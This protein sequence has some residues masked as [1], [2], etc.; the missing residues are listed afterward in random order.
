MSPT[1]T[2]TRTVTATRTELCL[3]RTPTNWLIKPF[4]TPGY[5]LVWHPPASC[6]R[7][8]LHRIQP[9]HRSRWYSD[10]FDRMHLFLDWR[11]GR[12][13]ISYT[14]IYIYKHIYKYIYIYIYIHIY[15]YIYIYI[16]VYIYIYI[17]IVIHR[18]ICFVLSDLIS[19]TRHT[20][21]S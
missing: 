19:V 21:F 10:I 17:Y 7:T 12:G 8:H 2:G 20:R 11:L 4:V 6:G 13:S 5:I 16:Y 9:V 15:T 3:P 1:A 14:Y 18:Q